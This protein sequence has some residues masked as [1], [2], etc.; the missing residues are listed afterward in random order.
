MVEVKPLMISSRPPRA[1]VRVPLVMAGVKTTR[2]G[3]TVNPVSH[4]VT[5][6]KKEPHANKVI[7]HLLLNTF[8]ILSGDSKEEPPAG[9]GHLTVPM[10]H[11]PAP[12]Q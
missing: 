4:P 2:P 3:L 9:Q 7:K 10:L 5:M 12:L 1:V 11:P 6:R 8:T